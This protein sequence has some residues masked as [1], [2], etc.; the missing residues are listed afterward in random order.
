MVDAFAVVNTQNLAGPRVLSADPIGD[1]VGPVGKVLLTFDSA[2]SASTF[3]P[4]LSWIP[5]S[6]KWSISSVTTET[7]PRLIAS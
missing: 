2:M 1:V 3:S 6:V 4:D 5:D 7:S